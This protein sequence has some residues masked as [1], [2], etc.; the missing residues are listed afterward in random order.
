MKM[1]TIGSNRIG[2][3]LLFKRAQERRREKERR[4]RK[5]RERKEL[6]L[7]SH[8]FSRHSSFPLNHQKSFSFKTLQHFFLSLSIFLF[9]LFL[10]F[11]FTNIL[12]IATTYFG[13]F[14]K[15]S[16]L[17]SQQKHETIEVYSTL[18]K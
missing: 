7:L 4:E 6:P 5:K 12:D 3:P 18:S 2:R 1:G 16:N 9:L 15:I 13:L 10:S 8:S 17:H 11:L 14:H